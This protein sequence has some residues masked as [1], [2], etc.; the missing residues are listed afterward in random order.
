MLCSYF[1]GNKQKV[2]ATWRTGVDGI[3]TPVMSEDGEEIDI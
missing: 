2:P 3:V 1:P